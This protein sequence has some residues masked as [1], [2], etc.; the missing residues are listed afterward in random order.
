MKELPRQPSEIKAALRETAAGRVVRR[1][2]RQYRTRPAAESRRIDAIRSQWIADGRPVPAPNALKIDVVRQ[3][4]QRF[5]PRVFIETG[6]YKGHT[7]DVIKDHVA[8]VWSIELSPELASRA[9]IKYARVPHVEICEGDSAEWVP[10][11]LDQLYEPALFWLDG[12]W[13]AG[14]TARGSLDTPIR[15]ELDAV[16][17]H[18]VDS[19][20]VL[21][22]DA[23]E[24]GQGDYPSIAELEATVRAH[25]PDWTFTV[26]AD[27]IRAHP[28]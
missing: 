23:R 20:V 28:R 14:E 13:S 19:H 27:I 15:A 5:G 12:H 22:D 7:I 11:L 9:R 21:I 2:R 1:W 8:K 16:L 24:F 26:D 17:N 3:H 25:R 10:R 18:R 6:T 4:V